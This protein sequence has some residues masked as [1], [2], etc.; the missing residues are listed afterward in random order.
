MNSY[1]VIS[2]NADTD[3]LEHVLVQFTAT[4]VALAAANTDIH[5][6]AGTNIHPVEAGKA[7]AVALR[8][9]FGLNYV[10]VGSNTA[11]AP[12]DELEL[13]ANGQ[14]VKYNAGTKIGIARDGS[15]AAGSIIRARLY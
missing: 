12:G 6:V 13:A 11:I 8:L 10:T 3:L 2:E 9:A 1:N 14:V 4:G 5:K 15:V 7:A